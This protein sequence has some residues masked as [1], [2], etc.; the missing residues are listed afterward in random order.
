MLQQRF[1]LGAE[2][3]IVIEGMAGDLKVIGRAE[4][5][6]LVESEGPLMVE[7]GGETLTL[8]GVAGDLRLW[9][10]QGAQIAIE[11]L[12]GDARLQN[13]RGTVRIDGVV[14]EVELSEVPHA[15]VEGSAPEDFGRNVA[16]RVRQAVRRSFSFSSG[17]RGMEQGAPSTTATAPSASLEA[18]RLTILR[19]LQEKKITAEEAERLLQAL[20]EG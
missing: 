7:A 12:S 10:P 2:P 6:I 3:K 9:V 17:R 19:M 18:E 4:E 13:I 1:V 8:E 15:R 20:G 14:G 16:E 11:G 5:E